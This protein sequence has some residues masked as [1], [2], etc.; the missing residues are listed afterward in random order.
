MRDIKP[1][2]LTLIKQEKHLLLPRI[3]SIVLTQNLYD[4]L[5]QYVITAEKEEK[6][7]IFIKQMETHI[8]SKSRAPFSA[9]LEK[10]GFLDDGLEELRLLNWMEV[11]VCLYSVEF[12]NTEDNGDEEWENLIDFLEEQMVLKALPESKSIYVYP[13]NLTSY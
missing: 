13:M 4:I 12:M 1:Y 7:E 11:P 2:K 6:L 3:T 5:F 8:K 9:P 10:L